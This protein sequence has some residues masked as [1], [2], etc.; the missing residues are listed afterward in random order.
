M[1]SSLNFSNSIYS[2][3]LRRVTRTSRS[4]ASYTSFPTSMITRL[5]TWQKEYLVISH[6]R[7]SETQRESFITTLNTSLDFLIIRLN[8]A[9]STVFPNTNWTDQN[10]IQS[11]VKNIQTTKLKRFY[12]PST[13]G[14]NSKHSL[15]STQA[16]D[17]ERQGR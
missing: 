12:V 7:R 11:Q 8:G 2:P 10:E 4:S 13:K 17:L 5:K 6:I 9:I 3:A 16:C 1:K 14:T 15:C